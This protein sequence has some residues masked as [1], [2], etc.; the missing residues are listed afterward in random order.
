MLAALGL[1]KARL[2]LIS[3]NDM[4][5]ALEV[6]SHVRRA[7]PDL[8][9]MV[10]VRD[11]THVDELRAAGA[12]EVV[13]ETLEA[14]LTIASQ[15]LLLLGVP[16]R[17]VMRRVLAQRAKRYPLLRSREATEPELLIEGSDPPLARW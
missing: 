7:R 6:L 9:V 4:P 14:G 8:P 10:R 2:V 15:V 12:I 16:P 1:A 13:P 5:A 17:R 3:Y 11:E